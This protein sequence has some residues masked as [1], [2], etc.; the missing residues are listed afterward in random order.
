MKAYNDGKRADRADDQ[1]SDRQLRRLERYRRRRRHN[2]SCRGSSASSTGTPSPGL[3]P[4]MSSARSTHGS[5][6]YGASASNLSVLTELTE[7]ELDM[8][9]MNELPEE[10]PKAIMSLIHDAIAVNSS[11]FIPAGGVNGNESPKSD[12]G[13]INDIIPELTTR[14]TSST[15]KTLHKTMMMRGFKKIGNSFPLPKALKKKSTKHAAD[16]TLVEETL[17]TDLDCAF[18]GSKT[19][20]ALLQWSFFMNAPNYRTLREGNVKTYVQ[21]WPFSSEGKYMSTLVRIRRCEDNKMVWRLYF[22]GAPELLINQCRWIVDVDGAFRK[23][24]DGEVKYIDDYGG[25]ERHRKG[26]SS[27]PMFTLDEADNNNSDANSDIQYF[28]DQ[29]VDSDNGNQTSSPYPPIP[30][31]RVESTHSEQREPQQPSS[32]TSHHNPQG[33]SSHPSNSSPPHL[34]V[35]TTKPSPIRRSPSS[36]TGSSDTAIGNTPSSMRPSNNNSDEDED[37]DEGHSALSLLNL[38]E[39]FAENPSIPVLRLNEDTL[40]DLK[41]ETTQYASRALRTIGM[42]YRDFETLDENEIKHLETDIDWRSEK[43][44]VWLGPF[45]IEDPLRDRVAESVR[46]CQKAGI[47]VRM[48]TGDNLLTARAIATQR[49]IYTPGMG[50]I[51]MEGPEFRKLSSERLDEVV[52][53]LRVLA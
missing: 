28:N 40:S 27:I 15:N 53:R 21:F 19:E 48:V 51:I 47:T 23:Q 7:A 1:L 6:N 37:E 14:Q 35:I 26:S 30:L 13:D 38:S 49:G 29:V 22:K 33:T 39:D 36:D 17:Q 9:A 11:A 42:S 46:K 24:D 20:V 45:G 3:S 25:G 44:L 32:S 8:V 43:G 16:Q 4:V 2:H 41:R 10:G 12:N 50:G 5:I 34:S 52:P 18:E 31:L